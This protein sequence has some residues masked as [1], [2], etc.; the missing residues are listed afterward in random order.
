MKRGMDPME[1]V[2]EDLE[3]LRVCGDNRPFIY[4]FSHVLE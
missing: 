2:L 3:G 4:V 1:V